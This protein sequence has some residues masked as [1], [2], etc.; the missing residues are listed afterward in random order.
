MHSIHVACQFCQFTVELL[1]LMRLPMD[2]TLKV[3]S[4]VYLLFKTLFYYYDY[5]FDVS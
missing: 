2:K 4:A 1:C 5:P 3:I